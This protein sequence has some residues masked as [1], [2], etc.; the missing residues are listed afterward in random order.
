MYSVTDSEIDSS[1]KWKQESALEKEI[2]KKKGY[3]QYWG[4]RNNYAKVCKEKQRN[5][6]YLSHHQW[7]RRS[8]LAHV[9]YRMVWIERDV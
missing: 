5:K 9:S 8:D 2:V 7:F 3:M 1:C 4:M 6:L